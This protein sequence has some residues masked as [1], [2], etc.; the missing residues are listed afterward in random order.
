MVNPTLIFLYNIA[1]LAMPETRLFELRVLLLRFCGVN[2]SNTAKICSSVKIL[3]NGSLI[4]GDN[5]WIGP[6][7]MVIVAGNSK[8]HIHQNVDIAPRCL[9][10]TGTHDI[11]GPA[12]RAGRS[13]SI[14]ITIESGTWIGAGCT[15][16]AG[17]SLPKSSIFAAG[18]VITK[19]RRDPNGLYAGV[20][21]I[22]KRKL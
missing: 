22:L 4:I 17:A 9:I 11:G 13:H 8:I 21:A 3:G 20:P 7:T 19:N 18:S 6:G 16:T 14:S 15:I 12:R 5:V 10:A 2:I 1:C